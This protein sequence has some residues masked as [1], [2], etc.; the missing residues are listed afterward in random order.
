MDNIIA[1]DT[2]KTST[3]MTIISNKG[4]FLINFT[5]KK[6]NYKWIKAFSSE[7]ECINFNYNK[8]NDYSI[9]EYNNM[10]TYSDISNAVLEKCLEYI[11]HKENTYIVMEGY[12]F[13]S[14]TNSIFNLIEIG[15]SIRIKLFERIPNLKDY[16]IIAPTS[17]KQY[18]CEMVYGYSEVIKNKGRKNERTVLE[19]NRNR[20]GLAGGSFK[21]VDM[22][23]ALLDSEEKST[24][25]DLLLKHKSDMCGAK[26]VKKPVEDIIDSLWLANIY[27]EY[28]LPSSKHTKKVKK[29]ISII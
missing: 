3:G 9:N 21:K 17:V 11:D 26:D 2:S 15:Q 10:H 27:I 6:L 5:T 12:S 7:I 25:S 13:S 18:V 20:R 23:N 14:K 1:L 16:K 29:S 19:L 8:D 22:Y 28:F 24:F 4:R